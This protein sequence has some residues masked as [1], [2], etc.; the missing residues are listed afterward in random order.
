MPIINYKELEKYIKD[1][2]EDQFP[3][4]FLIYGEELLCK[5]AFEKLF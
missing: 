2:K 3:H 1:K 4:V 5:E